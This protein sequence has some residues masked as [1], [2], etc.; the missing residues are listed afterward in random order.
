MVSWVLSLGNG[1][2][3]AAGGDIGAVAAALDRD[4]AERRMIAQRLAGIG[5]EAA[6]ARALGDLLRDQR[7][8][9]VEAD[10]EHLVAGLEAGIGLL[11][12]HERP[13]A[14]DARR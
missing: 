14:A 10:V 9:A 4:A 8:R 3:D 5:A 1:G 2:V 7:H 13:E 12:L 6:A 11:V